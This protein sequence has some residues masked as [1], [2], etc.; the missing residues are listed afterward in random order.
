MTPTRRRDDQTS[1]PE[2]WVGSSEER[3]TE[4]EKI[5]PPEV[6]KITPIFGLL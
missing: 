5:A 3:T 2:K 6:E 4:A 1:S